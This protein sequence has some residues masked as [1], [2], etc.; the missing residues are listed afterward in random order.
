MKRQ[1]ESRKEASALKNLLSARK[2]I[3]IGTWNVRTM[4]ETGKAAQISA[5]M[6]NYKLSVLGLAETR[7]TKSGQQKLAT[8][9]LI[10]FA[11]HE[12][13]GA[14]HTEGVAFMLSREA[15][16][17]LVGWEAISPRF[18]KATF[19]TQIDKLKLNLIMCYA[20]TNNSD[21]EVKE[22]FYEQ[23]QGI[24]MEL[25]SRDIN[26]LLG[27]FNAKIGTDN[28]GYERVMGTHGLGEMNENGGM[29]LDTCAQYDFV[30]GGS[31]FPHKN[32]HK[33]TWVSPDH[34]TTNQIDHICIN[35]KFRRSL[36]DVKAKRGADVASDHHLVT[37][38]LKLKL[39]RHWNNQDG[40]RR[41]YNVSFLQDAEVKEHFKITLRNRFQALQELPED[42]GTDINTQ[43]NEFKEAINATCEEVLGRQKHAQQEWITAKTLK[44]I[45]SRK[46][47][48]S[49]VNN[50]RTR[51]A[52][53]AAQAEYTA[54]NKEVKKLVKQDKRNFVENLAKEAEEAAGCQNMKRLYD[55]TKKLSQKQGQADRPVKDKDGKPLVGEEQQMERW[56]EHFEELLNRPP[57]L[58]P[59]EILERETDLP[60][61]C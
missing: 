57:P 20:P 23:L 39:R 25:N 38:K 58:N 16:S 13:E 11:G 3:N 15:Q 26:V 40:R 17:A 10:L 42:E 43:W 37:A 60:I 28:T 56:A 49:A 35:T 44:K 12:T 29:F 9:E 47:K 33:A 46:E 59:P 30:V 31:V 6:R 32:I 5:E 27:D 51:S 24:L 22:Q 19:R 21:E 55:I 7:W 50:S 52:K 54:A 1:G 48:K 2:N 61:S 34:T 45:E 8:G 41:K 4:Y 18:I 53:M 36:L 14:H